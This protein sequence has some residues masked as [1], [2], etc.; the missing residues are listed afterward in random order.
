MA[1]CRCART[2]PTSPPSW[3]H[4]RMR[5]TAPSWRSTSPTTPAALVDNLS[6][7]QQARVSLACTLVGDPE[8][9]VLDEPTVGLDPV[10]RRDLWAIFH[11]LAA[12]GSHGV[13]VEPRH[14]RGGSVRPAAAHPR[15]S[16]AQRLSTLPELL[17]ATGAADAEAAFL[18]LIGC[19]PRERRGRDRP[20]R[21]C[22]MNAR[23]TLATAGRILRQLRRDHRTIALMLVVPCVL[24]GLLAWIYA[25]SRCRSS[26]GSDRPCSGS[27]RSSSCS[28]SPAWRPCANAPPAPWSGCS[29]PPWQG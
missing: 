25:D 23:I 2:S 5:S 9:L 15:G 21:E 12:P 26:T 27:S 7:G 19:R 28:S 17:A 16:G 8:V 11:R 24:L 14:G 10:L 13:R 1:T 29:P 6:G 22:G 18:A 3:A 4:P 20:A